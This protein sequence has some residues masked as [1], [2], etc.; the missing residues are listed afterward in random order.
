LLS[1]LRL[2]YPADPPTV[3]LLATPHRRRSPD[4][5]A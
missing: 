5:A 1:P 4:N 3:S 2:Q